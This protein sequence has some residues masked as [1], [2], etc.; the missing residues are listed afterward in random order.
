MQKKEAEQVREGVR[1]LEVEED[2]EGGL[3]GRELLLTS[4]MGLPQ[5]PWWTSMVPQAMRSTT[6][7]PVLSKFAPFFQAGFA[8]QAG[9]GSGA[10]SDDFSQYEGSGTKSG[11][12][13]YA[14]RCGE[15]CQGE[16]VQEVGQQEMKCH[17]RG[18]FM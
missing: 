5:T 4:C 7:H 17:K 15:G 2:L 18:F 14:D 16:P 12:P 10:A 3:G 9:Y 11:Y 1:R 6:I 13:N 8:D